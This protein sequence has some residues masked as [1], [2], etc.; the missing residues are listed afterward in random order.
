ME[1]EMHNLQPNSIRDVT[2]WLD[3]ANIS[4]EIIDHAPIDGTASGSSTTT[5]TTPEQGAKALIMMIEN[6]NPV[7]VVVRGPDRV[8]FRQ[9]KK[10]TGAS[11]VRLASLQEIHQITPLSIG[12]LHP[13]GNLLNIP[14]Y[15]DRK[16]LDQE[17]I[18]CGTGS[19]TQSLI[20]RA[21]DLKNI[22]DFI[23]GDFTK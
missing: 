14:T 13:F 10:T 19:P 9:I 20:V 17:T 15:F 5:R 12:T 21:A 8:D 2:N 1:P 23:L 3:T 16:L 4:Y 22:H 7:M 6:K 18:V 11:D